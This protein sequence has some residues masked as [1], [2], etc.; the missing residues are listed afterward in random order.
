MDS[1]VTVPA[2]DT[3]G[4]SLREVVVREDSSRRFRSV[5]AGADRIERSDIQAVPNVLGE[6]DVLR[7]LRLL[8]GVQS[9]SEGNSGLYV[10]GGSAGH[11]LFLLDGMEL[12]NPSHLM[13][14]FSV[15]NPYTVGH[16]D[17]YKGNAPVPLQGRLA[18]SV[19]VSSVEP[20]PGEQSF[21]AGLGTLSSSLSYVRGSADGRF[22]LVT[23][24]R[25]SYLE[26]LGWLMRPLVEDERNYF[27]TNAYHFEDFNGKMGYRPNATTQYSLAWYLGK[28]AFRFRDGNLRYDASTTWGNR[29]LSLEVQHTGTDASLWRSSLSFHGTYSDLTGS[30]LENG[31]DFSSALNQ[32][33]WKSSLEKRAERQ[34]IQA[35]ME[36][37][38][39]QS[40][41]LRLSLAYASDTLRQHHRFS[42]AG[43]VLYAGDCLSS[44]SGN[45]LWYAGLRAT[46]NAALG[47]YRYGDL[48]V[49]SGRVARWWMSLSPVVSVS[50]YPAP[51]RSW[52]ASFSINE[53]NVHL[54]GLSS[55]PLPYDIWVT[56]TPRLRPETASQLTGGYYVQ[57]K[58]TASVE[59][60]VKSM[61]HQPLFNVV[62][63]NTNNQG[64]EDQFFEGKGWAYGLDVSV[65]RKWQAFSGHIRYSY[66]RSFRSYSQ[67]MDGRWFRDKYDRPHDLNLQLAYTPQGPWSFHVLW[68]FASGC[69]L[70]L[71]S[72]RWW[73]SGMI[74]NDYDRFNGFRLPAYHRLDLSA[75]YRLKTKR[76]KESVLN[77]SLI[78]LYNR[79]NPYFAYFKVFMG[80]S[81]YDLQVK[82][83]Q[84]S[85]FPI[86][87]SI[88]WR[89]QI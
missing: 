60:Y 33:D 26:A 70:T 89:F 79:A 86:L 49:A 27:R 62:T 80:N 38:V 22:T 2:A 3:L 41:P 39:Q 40:L 44:P 67:I 74:M 83:Y 6:S 24:Y 23:G 78:N 58:W 31:L 25:R 10:R 32:F 7:A 56:A 77:V 69:N 54:A 85:L 61:Q 43:L 84:I 88:G 15:F 19:V 21:R 63:D 17:V 35:G 55:I 72:G 5:V 8:P 11:N 37:F 48:S 53:Q 87:P 12:L 82:S 20:A 16:L 9:V 46:L 64:F 14:L 73:M 45:T 57:G 71:P 76:F 28:D 68:T 47:P 1:F 75:D 34:L 65:E 59:A 50:H 13:G 18:S 66:A 29:A 52:K 36:L 4:R 30:M 51:G 81:R 42:N